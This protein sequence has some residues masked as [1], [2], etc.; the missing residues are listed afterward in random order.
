M[1]RGKGRSQTRGFDHDEWNLNEEEEKE[2]D[3][4]K[5]K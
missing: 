3:F 4:K 5:E 1:I 2:G